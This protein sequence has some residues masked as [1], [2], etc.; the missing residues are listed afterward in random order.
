MEA[1]PFHAGHGEESLTMC[2]IAGLF[3]YA[4]PALV[5][6]EAVARMV[7]PLRHRGPDDQGVHL[8]GTVGLGH[9]RLSIIDVAGGHQPIFNEDRTVAVVCNGEIYNHRE[10]RQGLRER[11]HRFATR[12]DSEVIVHLWEELGAGC[13]E[14]LAGMF[15]LAVADFRRRTLLL[16]RDRIGK[17][18][19]YLADDGRRLGFASELKSL[20]AAG[21]AGPEIDP[22]ALDLYLAYGYVPA[23]W[24]IFRG[25]TKLPAGH[26]ALVDERGA[27]IER[28][29]DV[30]NEGAQDAGPAADER[31]ASELERLL[32]TA[33]RDR[34]ESDVPLGAFL[35]GGID[36]GT[37]VSLMSEASPEP[38]RTHTVGFADRASDE[39]EDAAA[40]ARALGADH[41]ETEVRPDL[42]D[43]LPRI[44]WHLDEP[45][46]DPSSVPTW[47]VSRETRR[48]VTVA[49]SGDGGD[50]LFAGYGEK[51]RMHLMEERL[52]SFL[53]APLRQGLFPALGRRWPRSPRLPRA[54]R[55]GGLFR[56]LA[57]EAPRSYDFDR[58]LIPPH[59]EERL[60]GEDL[61]QR[62]RRFDP[63]AAIEPHLARAPREPLA[64]ALYLDLKTWLADDGLVKVDR[65]SMAHALEVR[66]PLLDHRIIEFA[67]RLPARLKLA[68][69]TTKVLLRR[70]AERRLPAGILARPKRGFAPPVSRWLREDLRDFS[71][72]LLLAPDAFGG[73]LFARRQVERLLDDHAALRLDAGW[74][75]WTLLMLEVWGREVARAAA[76]PL[77]SDLE[78]VPSAV[79]I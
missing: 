61:V 15:A 54:L 7:A 79:G 16:A 3:H 27:R 60:F 29:W 63:F 53:P 48:R 34:L 65:M 31:L 57:V 58:R 72:D 6:R 10:L 76:A 5:I 1:A 12:S 78:E 43:V 32:A 49:L 73:G 14:R 20:L 13:V 17:K 35:S 19:L 47:Y 44:A 69:G 42:A 2:G 55:L 9:A 56:N 21:L 33:V 66:C 71:R 24:T 26:L 36:S 77:P 23:P 46:A 11:G 39:R 64:R 50:E 75:L 41:V 70:V 28:Y 37:V 38:V 22:E 18:P 68:A 30:P 67:A 8:A 52:R 59:L 51:Y 45:F 40:V 25:A 62:R 74:A 4:E